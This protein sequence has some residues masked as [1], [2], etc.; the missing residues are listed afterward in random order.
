MPISAVDT[1]T[2]AFRHTKRQLFEPFRF[3]QWTRLAIVG[4]LAGE[5]GSG[6]GFNIPSGF[7][8]QTGSSRHFLD[9]GFGA[10]D[11]AL[12][13]GLIVVLVVAVLLFGII[14]IYVG[15]VM[16]FILFDSVLTREC[17]IRQ[18][19]SRRQ[20]HGWAYFLFQLVYVLAT[21]AGAVILVGI[22]ALFAYAMGWFNAPSEHVLA[23]VLGG[24]VVFFLVVV[25]FVAAAVIYV[26]TKDFVVPQM[27]LE[28][29]GVVEGWRRLWPMVQGEKGG[30][31]VYVGMKIVLAIGAGIAIGLVS[32]IVVLLV[33]IPVAALGF[34]VVY[35]GK[36]AGLIWNV[37]TIT[38]AVVV[39][40]ILFAAFLYLV[41]LI[42]VPAI[43]FFPAYSIY[44][45]APRYR[46]LS[47][48]LYP[49][50]P[51]PAAWDATGGPPPLTPAPAG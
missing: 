37:F 32:V 34:A 25:F 12:Y 13:A 7:P 5:A 23:L 42:S 15:S 33:A 3:W 50:P 29:V 2:L 47:L 4:L 40:C 9:S 19:W 48:M 44:F 30:Y 45:F 10:I 20:T 49:P 11:P 24:I 22:P 21:L 36:S 16:R 46:A 1:I 38:I 17:H 28:G 31:A 26:L 18:G 39:G 14:M 8:Q 6:G 35:A 27:A 41:A 43:V 51:P